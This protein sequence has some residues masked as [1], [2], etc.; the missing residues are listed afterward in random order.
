M[1]AV[2]DKPGCTAH[3]NQFS[4]PTGGIRHDLVGANRFMV[5]IMR[6]EY[7]S[8]G[9]NLIADF[10]FDN[11]IA[12]MDAF[13]PTSATLEVEAPPQVDLEAGVPGVMV[14]VTNE[15][16]HKLPTGY[17]EGRVMWLEVL[18]EYDGQQVY[19]SGAWDQRTGMQQDEQLRTYQAVGERWSDGT[20]FH[21]LLNDH[22]AED[23]RIPP[24]GLTPDLQ[25]D[26]VGDRYTLQPDGT[27]PHYDQHTY[28]FPAAPQIADA[29]PQDPDDDE[30]RVTVR[31]RY[32]VNTPEYIDFLAAQAGEAGTHVATLFDLA[33]GAPPLVL[34]EQ[35]VAIPIVGFGAIADTGADTTAGDPTTTG[36]TTGA[37]TTGSGTLPGGSTGLM[38][39]AGSED[40][41][42]GPPADDSGGG[43]CACR[44]GSPRP[45][46]LGWLPWLLLGLRRRRA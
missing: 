46:G 5:Q 19:S 17:S 40:S 6:D 11:T 10:F 44:G 7:G 20:T 29:T 4:H 30:L 43:D 41:S 38:G 24:R 36:S 45:A 26:P 16:G 33:G 28:D 2:A 25:T 15:T 39:T 1:P 21:L 13:L 23:T 31:L 9:A 18:A 12:A 27:W 34:T 42:G 3:L 22:W 8:A 37:D 32:L 35:T 14:T